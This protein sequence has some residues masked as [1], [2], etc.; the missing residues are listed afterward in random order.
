MLGYPSE[1]IWMY[2]P[3][4]TLPSFLPFEEEDT[5]EIYP[6]AAPVLFSALLYTFPPVLLYKD[7]EEEI[8]DAF[9]RLLAAP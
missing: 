4:K 5:I 3:T 7:G 2:M 6:D 9:F 8:V 1:Q